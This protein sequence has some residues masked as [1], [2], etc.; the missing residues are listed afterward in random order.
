VGDLGVRAHPDLT[1][2]TDRRYRSPLN[3]P[4]LLMAAGCWVIILIV[5][6]VLI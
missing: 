3:W 1:D 6:L 2:M 4:V 5:V